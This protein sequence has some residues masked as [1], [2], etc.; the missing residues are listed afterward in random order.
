MVTTQQRPVSASTLRYTIVGCPLGSMLVAATDNGLRRVSLGDDDIGLLADLHRDHADDAIRSDTSGL[1]QW[2][3]AILHNLWGAL[4][5]AELP[6]DIASTDFQRRVWL[7][8]RAIPYGCTRTYTDIAR[9]MGRPDSVRAVAN[10]CAANRLAVVIPCH[11]VLREDG[12]LGGFRWGFERKRAL[13]EFE[14]KQ[15]G[16]AGVRDGGQMLL[17]F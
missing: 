11:R 3:D 8:L 16:G 9:T 7:E 15:R 17:E 12:S 2:A 14:R 1:A 13:I 6:I 5:L 10:A 4:P